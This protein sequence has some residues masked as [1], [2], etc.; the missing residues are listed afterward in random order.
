MQH[1]DG[2]LQMFLY[3]YQNTVALQVRLRALRSEFHV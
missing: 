1:F 3:L 2:V